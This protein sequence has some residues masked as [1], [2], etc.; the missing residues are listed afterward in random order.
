[1]YSG[2][3]ISASCDVLPAGRLDGHSTLCS[4]KGRHKTSPR[5]RARLAETIALKKILMR[6]DAY[7]PNYCYSPSDEVS[8]FSNKDRGCK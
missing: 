5:G 2:E 4:A 8:V 3:F 6:D 1:M 7:L